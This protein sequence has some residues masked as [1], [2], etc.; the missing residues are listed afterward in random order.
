MITTAVSTLLWLHFRSLVVFLIIYA[1]ADGTS[2]AAKQVEVV[3][4]WKSLESLAMESTPENK[5]QGCDRAASLLC[6][7]TQ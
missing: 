4:S 6:G 1:A 5:Y 7:V 2:T 3:Y